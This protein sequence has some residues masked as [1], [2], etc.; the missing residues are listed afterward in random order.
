GR[1]HADHVLH[2][3]IVRA[4]IGDVVEGNEQAEGGEHKAHH[5]LGVACN[6]HAYGRFRRDGSLAM[7]LAMRL[8]SSIQAPC[9]QAIA[10]GS[11]EWKTPTKSAGPRSKQ[12]IGFLCSF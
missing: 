6:Q 7:L 10:S 2:E 11:D 8:A 4:V 12:L 1:V 5:D 9:R 3:E